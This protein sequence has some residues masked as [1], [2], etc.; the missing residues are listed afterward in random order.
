MCGLRGQSGGKHCACAS[1][2]IHKNTCLGS[3]LR[4]TELGT[5]FTSLVWPDVL[6]DR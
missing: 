4:C 1:E 6:T 3:R 5:R 2:L